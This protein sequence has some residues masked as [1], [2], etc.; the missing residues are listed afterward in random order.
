MQVLDVALR[1]MRIFHLAQTVTMLFTWMFFVAP[2]GDAQTFTVL[3]VAL[4]DKGYYFMQMGLLQRVMCGHT[5]FLLPPS[6]N[7][8]PHCESSYPNTSSPKV[9]DLGV[10]RLLVHTACTSWSNQR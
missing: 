9:Y 10:A 6:K 7:K 2:N 5:H 3:C 4:Y 8:K 1:W